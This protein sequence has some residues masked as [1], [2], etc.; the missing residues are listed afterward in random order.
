MDKWQSLLLD[1]KCFV[2]AVESWLGFVKRAAVGGD[3]D[4]GGGAVA[5]MTLAAVVMWAVVMK[6]ELVIAVAS[7]WPARCHDDAV[8]M[9]PVTSH[10]K[11]AD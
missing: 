5:V 2:E 11:A 4:V 7:Y 8:P 6:M 9:F 3:D 1:G 10:V